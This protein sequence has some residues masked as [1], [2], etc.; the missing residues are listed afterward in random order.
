MTPMDLSVFPPEFQVGAMIVARD[1][2]EAIVTG[3][4]TDYGLFG[5]GLNI[6]MDLNDWDWGG[7]RFITGLITPHSSEAWTVIEE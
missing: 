1:G 5:G 4:N 6:L 7:H 3:T 2:T